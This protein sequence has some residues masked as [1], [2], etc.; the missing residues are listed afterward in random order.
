ML[1]GCPHVLDFCHLPPDS[2]GFGD[3]QVVADPNSE[4]IA[5]KVGKDV[6]P[7]VSIQLQKN[8]ESLQDQIFNFTRGVGVVD[9][10]A[11]TV[12]LLDDFAQL[13]ASQ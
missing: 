3:A 6:G 13:S 9:F 4:L 7:N 8:R 11:T 5:E 10:G 2:E 12:F 1:C